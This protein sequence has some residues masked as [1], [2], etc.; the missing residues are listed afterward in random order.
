MASFSFKAQGTRWDLGDLNHQPAVFTVGSHAKRLR[1][2]YRR[3]RGR[4]ILRFRFPGCRKL[5]SLPLLGLFPCPRNRAHRREHV[6]AALI[7]VTAAFV[8]E[9]FGAELEAPWAEGE[10]GA[11]LVRVDVG[12]LLLRWLF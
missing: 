9:V 12:G 10:R 3:Q 11:F 8:S 4:K 7:A 6:N 5:T 1:S 2:S